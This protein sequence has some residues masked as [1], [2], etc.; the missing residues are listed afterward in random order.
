MEDAVRSVGGIDVH[1]DGSNTRDACRCSAVRGR[2]GRG[3]P[4]EVFVLWEHHLMC[5]GDYAV[6][7]T[8][9]C[10]HHLRQTAETSSTIRR[11]GSPPADE[12]EVRAPQ[13]RRPTAATTSGVWRRTLGAASPLRARPPCPLCSAAHRLSAQTTTWP[14]EC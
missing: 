4:S 10:E 2:A 14:L 9:N 7:G 12:G 8:L 6:Y 13:R 1:R 5:Y 11:A 3:A